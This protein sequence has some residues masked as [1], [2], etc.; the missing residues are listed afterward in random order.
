MAG[1][2]IKMTH[3]LPD[4]PEVLGISGMTGI[5]RFEVV[6]RLFVMWRWFDQHT[7]NGNAV[8]V[9]KV[10]LSECLFGYS[11]DTKFI[12]SVIHQGW[13]IE[14]EEGIRVSNFDAHI[15]ETA[16][17]RALTAKRVA[18][19]KNKSNAKGNA[20]TVTLPLPSALP[21]EDIR[22]DSKQPPISPLGK[23]K[24]ITFSQWTN[25]VRSNGEKLVSDYKPVWE[26]AAQ[27][28]LP[29]DWI[30]IAWEKFKERYTSD[31]KGAKKRYTDWRR[32][33]LRAVKENW[34]KLWYWSE[35]DSAW[36][37]TS[38]GIAADIETRVAE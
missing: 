21:R 14:G 29:E 28:K 2:W 35:S 3:E 13:L 1:D 10:T 38:I 27:V 37:L 8:G 30:G 19:S 18:K 22:I 34:A 5:N 15:S 32:V 23:E 6:G 26:Y 17:T 25:S 31:E 4:K 20:L 7:T 9:T 16:K 36:R 11:S 24:S 33:F 12:E